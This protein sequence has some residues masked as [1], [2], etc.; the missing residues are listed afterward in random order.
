[1][2]E[3]TRRLLTLGPDHEPLW[4][5]LYVRKV[6]EVWAAMFLADNEL[7]PEPGTLKGIALFGATP[8]EAKRE[9]LVYLGSFD[10][11]N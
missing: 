4:I 7:P 3:R 6:D 10:P 2:L 8:E 5:R 9:A 1:M 11:Q